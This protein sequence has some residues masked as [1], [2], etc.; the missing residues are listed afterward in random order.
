[1]SKLTIKQELADAIKFDDSLVAHAI[2]Y[3][4]QK[5]LVQLDDPSSSLPI[6]IL[7]FDIITNW[8][9]TNYLQLCTVKLFTIRV[10]QNRQALYLAHDE[11][12]ASA[13]HFK[14]YGYLAQRIVEAPHEMDTSLYCEETGK[15]RVIRD[16]KRK[17]V[18]FPCWLG[19]VGLPSMHA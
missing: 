9:D 4:L 8:M 19:E 17:M 12:E 14:M 5:G 16:M 3:A 15:H 2:Y 13:Q 10:N 18:E 7:D 11:N 1:M 6:P